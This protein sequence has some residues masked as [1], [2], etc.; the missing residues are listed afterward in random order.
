MIVVRV[1]EKS[2][3]WDATDI[4]TGASKGGPL[5]DAHSFHAQLCGFDGTHVTS[6][7]STDHNQI[8]ILCRVQ[9]AGLDIGNLK[10]IRRKKK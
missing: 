9:A 6:G 4:E 1:V 3:G 7:A 5:F 8:G 10:D 2:F